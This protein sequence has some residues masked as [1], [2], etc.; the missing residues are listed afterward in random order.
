MVGSVIVPD[1][2]TCTLD[3]TTVQGSIVVK[4]R[5]TLRATGVTLSGTVAGE[6][7]GTV[8]VRSS[9]IGNGVSISKGGAGRLGHAGLEQRHGRT[10]ARRR[11]R[12]R[13]AERQRGRRQHPGEH[14]H[15]RADDTGRIVNGLQCQDN[16]PAPTGGGNVA[17]QKQGQCLAL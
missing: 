2:A 3:G 11:P 12:Y 1:D 5:A 6:G 4:S 7:P 8:D 9:S 14:E 13:R 10:P 16:R 17:A 15:R